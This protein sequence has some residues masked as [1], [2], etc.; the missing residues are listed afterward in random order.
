MEDKE[1]MTGEL[2]FSMIEEET[3]KADYKFWKTKCTKKAKNEATV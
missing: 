3:K 1:R 2:Y